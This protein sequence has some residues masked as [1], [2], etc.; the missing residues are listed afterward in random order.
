MD[1]LIK[2]FIKAVKDWWNGTIV[3]MD[4]TGG[5]IFISPVIERHWTSQFAHTLVEF[6]LK[7][8]KRILGF[9]LTIV[10]GHIIE[11]IIF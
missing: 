1:N 7:Y 6:Y 2:K 4:E 10:A 9:I 11:K 3:P 5:L 8:W